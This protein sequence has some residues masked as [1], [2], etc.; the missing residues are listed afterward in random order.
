MERHRRIWP[1]VAVAAAVCVGLI[2]PFFLPYLQ[3]QES[4][5]FAAH[6]ERPVFRE[7]QRVAQLVGVGASLVG[8]VP[9]GA[10]RR[11]VSR[12]SSRLC[13]AAGARRS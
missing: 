7:R 9:V 12:A 1:A 5:G 8:A 4:T 11:A 6:V 2:A 10:K 13:S 3:M